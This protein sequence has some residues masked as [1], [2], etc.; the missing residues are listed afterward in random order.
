MAQDK[1]TARRFGF[2]ALTP[3]GPDGAGGL[4]PRP[5]VVAVVDYEP[6][7][8]FSPDQ[9]SFIKEFFSTRSQ[10]A[11]AVLAEFG[12]PLRNVGGGGMPPIIRM[13]AAEHAAP[14]HVRVNLVGQ[15]LVEEAFGPSTFTEHPDLVVIC[16]DNFSPDGGANRVAHVSVGPL[17]LTFD[18]AFFSQHASLQTRLHEVMHTM[19][20]VDVYGHDGQR[21]APH[22]LMSSCQVAGGRATKLPDPWHRMAWRLTEP[23]VWEI[24]DLSTRGLS[25]EIPMRSAWGSTYPT[26]LLWRRDHSE[27]ECVM[28]ELRNHTSAQGPLLLDSDTD[29]GFVVWLLK[30]GED[31]VPVLRARVPAAAGNDRAIL[32][33]GSRNNLELGGWDPWCPA[34]GTSTVSTP[35]LRWL[36]GTPTGFSLDMELDRPGDYESGTVRVSPVFGIAQA[37]PPGMPGI[38]LQGIN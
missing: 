14:E 1:A 12:A 6:G 10:T 2:G 15:R 25:L 28:V 13:S 33:I 23:D 30:V 4:R 5:A 17:N 16:A 31:G 18:I 27:R 19:G 9:D 22:S 3:T 36:D 32:T 20:G 26:L 29:P 8:R 11:G 21:N 37:R 35:E 38:K 34:Q 7:E 24:S